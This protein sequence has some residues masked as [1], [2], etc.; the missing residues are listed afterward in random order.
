[1]MKWD[2]KI[3]L[4]VRNYDDKHNGFEYHS[5]SSWFVWWEDGNKLPGESNILQKSKEL[6]EQGWEL[7]SVTPRSGLTG[8]RSEIYGFTANIVGGGKTEGSSTDYA[9][10]TSEEMWVFK[11]PK[12]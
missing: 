9:G 2:Y 3:I 5:A 7:V 10:F 1:M 6:G 8:G 11:R 4:R 12:D